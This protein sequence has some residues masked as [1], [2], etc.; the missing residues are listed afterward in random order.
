[1]KTNTMNRYNY[2]ACRR[3]APAKYPN[4]RSTVNDLRNRI[5]DSLL[6]AAISLAFVV[7]VLFLLIL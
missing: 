7:V 2:D 3:G 1:M 5:V 6:A 4:S